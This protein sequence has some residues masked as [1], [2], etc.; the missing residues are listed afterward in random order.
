MLNN[1]P[2]CGNT[3]RAGARFCGNCGAT[4]TPPASSVSA[5]EVVDKAKE[6]ASKAGAAVGPAAA[7]AGAV[8]GPA[9]AKAGA[10]VGPAAAKAGAAVVPAAKGAAAAVTPVAKEAA[11]KGWAGS[12][13]GMSFFARVVTVGGRAAYSEVFGPLPAAHG[14]VATQPATSTVPAPIEP[15]AI[16]F[17]ISLLAGWAIFTLSELSRVIVIATIFVT[18]LVL[19]WLGIRRPYFTRMTF[20]GLV[21][22]LRQR[23]QAPNVPIYKF[24]ITEGTTGQPLDV[25]M[26][27]ERKASTE[28]GRSSGAIAQG[29]LVELW[30]IRDPGQNELRAWKVETVDTSGQ[31]VGT[32]TAP[33][34]IPLTVALFLPAALLLLGWLVTLAR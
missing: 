1:C 21:G 33:R 25:V 13:R 8:V 12:K 31:V 24:R 16:L 20:G 18:L 14:Q 34:L 23:G 4:L 3:N 32:L 29:A 10:A 15:A 7:K 30:G 26:V 19:S 5:A 22:R 17:V 9:A 11:V 6:M 2:K 27:G 28:P